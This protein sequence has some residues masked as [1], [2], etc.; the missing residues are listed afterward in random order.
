MGRAR[1]RVLLG[2]ALGKTS[3]VRVHSDMFYV[4][5]ELPRGQT[6]TFAPESRECAAYVVGGRLSAGDQK[7]ATYDMAI[8]RAG[9]SLTLHA[10]EDARFVLLGGANLGKRFIEWNFVSSDAKNIAEAKAEWLKGPGTKRFPRV[11]GDDVEFIPL[12]PVEPAKYP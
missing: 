12:P 1:F 10:D 7:I 5:V 4:D 2:S 9:T 11:P 6:F 8:A 3:P